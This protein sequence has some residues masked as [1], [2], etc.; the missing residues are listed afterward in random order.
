MEH[1]KDDRVRVAFDDGQEHRYALEKFGKSLR[2]LSED[3]TQA[4]L[5]G[6]ESHPVTDW[7]TRLPLF[8]LQVLSSLYSATLGPAAK[9]HTLLWLLARQHRDGIGGGCDNPPARGAHSCFVCVLCA[10]AALA[11][12]QHLPAP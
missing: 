4:E 6:A 9:E 11:T 1:T 8:L 7:L 2:R 3:E 10:G 5:L 12:H